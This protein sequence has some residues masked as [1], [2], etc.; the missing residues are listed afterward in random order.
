MTTGGVVRSVVLHAS[1]C[2]LS[3]SG[4][5]DAQTCSISSTTRGPLS[6][7]VTTAMTTTIHM[8]ALVSV[9]VTPVRTSGGWVD[10]ARRAIVDAAF[11][12]SANRSYTLQITNGSEDSD[13]DFARQSSELSAS[14]ASDAS[15]LSKGPVQQATFSGPMGDHA[16]FLLSFSRRLV[17][18]GTA[19]PIRLLVTIVAP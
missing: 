18:T 4:R 14:I 11:G 10:G 15:E 6:C 13:S 9:S 8:P 16:P 19:G 5:V 1:V 3:V 2:V 12:V 17:D 7:A